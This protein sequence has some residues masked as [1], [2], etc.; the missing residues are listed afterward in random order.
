MSRKKLKKP[1]KTNEL[2]DETLDG[3][4]GGATQIEHALI[5]ANIEID[6]ISSLTLLGDNL[7]TNFENMPTGLK[8]KKGTGPRSG[9]PIRN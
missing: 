7:D 8:K 3:V 1:A 2:S 5:S 9:K 6:H 4:T